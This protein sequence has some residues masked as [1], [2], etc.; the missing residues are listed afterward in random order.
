MEVSSIESVETPLEKPKKGSSKEEK[1]TSD[2]EKDDKKEEPKKS[3]F[4]SFFCKLIALLQFL[5][6]Y[7]LG[8]NFVCNFVS[9]KFLLEETKNGTNIL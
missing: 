2:S 5:I 8:S 1:S 6:L 4:S 7:K 9:H 3:A